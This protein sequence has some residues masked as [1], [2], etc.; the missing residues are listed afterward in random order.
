MDIER[1]SMRMK[2]TITNPTTNIS[3]RKTNS[4]STQLNMNKFANEVIHI[5]HIYIYYMI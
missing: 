4:N 2:T 3:S 5:Y 1:M